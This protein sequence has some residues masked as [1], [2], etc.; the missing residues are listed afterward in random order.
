[1]VQFKK[2]KILKD[3]RKIPNYSII[4]TQQKQKFLFK[5]RRQI[6]RI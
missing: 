1:M 3:A 2:K 5:D 4:N 6:R